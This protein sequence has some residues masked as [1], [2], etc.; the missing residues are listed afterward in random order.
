ME[1]LFK[2]AGWD[3]LAA[4]D[5]VAPESRRPFILSGYR[6]P[7]SGGCACSRLRTFVDVHNETGNI[8]THVPWVI[9][10]A[11]CVA[12]GVHLPP[13]HN[14]MA[15]SLA[16]SACFM[17]ASSVAYHGLGYE[18][19]L[20]YQKTLCFDIGGIVLTTTTVLVWGV[21]LAFG[22]SV[23][24]FS[25]SFAACIVSVLVLCQEVQNLPT[26]VGVY[27][28]SLS[29]PLV[30]AAVTHEATTAALHAFTGAAIIALASVIYAAKVPERF[31]PGYFDFVFQ[32]H[33]FWHMFASA[34]VFHVFRGF[35]EE[36][37]RQR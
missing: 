29:I 12:D 30:H 3:G 33:Q 15:L 13:P 37:T 22:V 6:R 31:R 11:K 9:V 27:I 14:V 4:I 21:Y 25:Y 5:E 28:A 10:F 19:R 26:C 34:A 16:G 32:S 1:P 36:A 2:P 7:C 35:S 23:C 24:F 8:A 17:C 20:M 18:S